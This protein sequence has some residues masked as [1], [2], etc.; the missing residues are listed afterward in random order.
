MK[1]DKEKMLDG[2]CDAYI[3]KPISM[4]AFMSTIERFLP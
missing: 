3:A 4:D 2:G 1:G